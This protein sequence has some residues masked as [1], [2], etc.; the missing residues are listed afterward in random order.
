[1]QDVQLLQDIG[2]DG[3][4]L[5]VGQ[6]HFAD[7]EFPVRLR[8]VR[9]SVAGIVPDGHGQGRR[10]V[11]RQRVRLAEIETLV[12]AVVAA[13]AEELGGA[14]GLGLEGGFGQILAFLDGD[15]RLVR[16]ELLPELF[17]LGEFEVDRADRVALAGGDVIGHVGPFPLVFHFAADLG[18]VIADVFEVVDDV[19]GTGVHLAF[20]VENQLGAGPADAQERG[21]GLLR[22]VGREFRIADLLAFDLDLVAGEAILPF[23]ETLRGAARGKETGE[24]RKEEVFAV[25]SYKINTFP[26]LI[27]KNNI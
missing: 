10:P 3:D 11:V 15:V 18:P 4:F 8:L 1:M 24:D 9:G 26:L 16:L 13:V 7:G 6:G 2:P 20:V 5:R 19:V 27:D 23:R 14:D 17:V 12:E 22:Q 21:A 25:H